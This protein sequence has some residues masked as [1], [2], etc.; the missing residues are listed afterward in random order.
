ML[1][2]RTPNWAVPG[3]PVVCIA[4]GRWN[5]VTG[6]PNA[7]AVWPH[8][9]FIYTISEVAQTAEGIYLTLRELGPANEYC[10]SGFAPVDDEE[11][12]AKL[13]NARLVRAPE[14]VR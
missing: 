4:S 1:P 3:Q 7:P 9:H 13:F 12:E 6:H 5:E 2:K 10:V 11:V 14:S 8:Q